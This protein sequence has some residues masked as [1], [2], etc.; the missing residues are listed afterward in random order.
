M[1][2]EGLLP[3]SGLHPL[4]NQH[5]S[6][7]NGAEATTQALDSRRNEIN[8]SPINVYVGHKGNERT[9]EVRLAGG[10]CTFEGRLADDGRAEAKWLRVPR[11]L[12]GHGYGERLVRGMTAALIDY[13]ATSLY[14]DIR[15][16]AALNIRAK[17]FGRDNLVFIDSA[18]KQIVPMTF[19]QAMASLQ[20][21]AAKEKNLEH[22]LIGIGVVV[23]LRR[24]NTTGWERP[25]AR[26]S[27]AVIDQ[28]PVKD[29][30][31][32]EYDQWL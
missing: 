15:N 19:E 3:D 25:P 31:P 26:L 1:M 32:E 2:S 27:R 5:A 24:V 8:V 6:A 17:V 13:G 14:S 23:D 4:V 16:E 12:R 11:E 30:P 29:Q 10:E 22:R 9:F 18:S 20:Q 28:G 7:S 21:A